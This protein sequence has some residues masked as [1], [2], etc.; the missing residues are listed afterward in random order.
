MG[1][2]VDVLLW[3]WPRDK[4]GEKFGRQV[5][6]QG[7]SKNQARSDR[8]RGLVGH[9]TVVSHHCRCQAGSERVKERR[10]RG[11]LVEV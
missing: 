5:K 9:L 8:H 2:T 1:L 4:L 11:M 3:L 7:L 6:R 10:M